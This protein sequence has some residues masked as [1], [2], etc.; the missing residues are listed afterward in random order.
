MSRAPK[1]RCVLIAGGIDNA[2]NASRYE[3]DLS[4]WARGLQDKGFECWLCLADGSREEWPEGAEYTSAHRANLL[5][6]FEWLAEVD[7]EGVALVV[8]SNHGNK[9]GIALWG[10]DIF[11]PHDLQK[12]MRPVQAVSAFIMGQCHAG[13]F[14]WLAN[15]RTVVLT[16]CQKDEVSYPCASPPGYRYDEFLYQLGVAL[17][18]AP[19]DAPKEGPARKQLSLAAAFYWAA[20]EDRREETPTLFDPH[21]LAPK[22]YL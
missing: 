8:V 10:A 13:V 1:R 15:E 4:W 19:S 16:A 14:G 9:E 21:Q 18:G 2:R 5:L 3:K 20:S 12:A 11:S 6:A 7:A 17:I 22:L